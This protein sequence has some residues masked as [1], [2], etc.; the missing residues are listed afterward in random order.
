MDRALL[1]QSS[2]AS[3]VDLHHYLI[4]LGPSFKGSRAF[5]IDVNGNVIGHAIDLSGQHYAVRWS[6]I[7]EPQT[8]FQFNVCV[9]ALLSGR[10]LMRIPRRLKGVG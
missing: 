7:P 4:G 5:S 8:G 6:L 2:A 10:L 1:W 3:V 9:L